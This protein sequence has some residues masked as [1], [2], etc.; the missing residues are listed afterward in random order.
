[1]FSISAE[2]S[3]NPV[4]V[5]AT[6]NRGHSAEEITE[7]CMAKIL[8]ISGDVPEP[9]RLQIDAYKDNLRSVLEFYFRQM[10]LSERTSMIAK[11]KF[12]GYEEAAGTVRNM[13]KL[14]NL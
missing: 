5:M 3:T 4:Q 11:L 10:A 14:H 9:I 7:M 12:G 2:V 6:H 13:E 8:H 1:M